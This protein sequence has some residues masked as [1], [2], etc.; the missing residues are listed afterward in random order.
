MTE[1]ILDLEAVDLLKFKQIL[2][3]K[4]YFYVK[5]KTAKLENNIFKAEQV[6][7]KDEEVN[8]AAEDTSTAAETTLKPLARGFILKES[9]STHQEHKK[10]FSYGKDLESTNLLTSRNT[11]PIGFDHSSYD[12]YFRDIS[13]LSKILT[14]LISEIYT[15]SKST[16]QKLC[17]QGESISIMRI[18]VYDALNDTRKS[19]LTR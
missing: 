13:L 4:G 7:A 9:G 11:W 14:G 3:E 2:E 5:Y 10:I 15:G 8:T 18:F 6:L 12:Y 17:D 19:I 16:W 1:N